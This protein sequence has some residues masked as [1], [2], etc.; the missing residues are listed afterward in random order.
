MRFYTRQ[1]SLGGAF[2]A[3]FLLIVTAVKG[4]DF[5]IQ[6]GDAV[7]ENVPG[8]G[9]GNLASNTETDIYTFSA[10]AGQSVFFERISAASAY[11][12]W[13][14]W[15]V[16]AP[17]GKTVL[18]SFFG[19]GQDGRI[20]LPE[21]GTYTIKLAA[22]AKD[23]TYFGAYSFRLRF[24]P[25]DPVFPIQVGQTVARDIPSEGAGD[26][27][28]AGARDL[29]SF[30]ASAGDQVSV[31]ELSV[32]SAFKGWLGWELRNPA[33]QRVADSWFDTRNEA[34]VT[35]PEAGVYQIQVF[36]KASDPSFLGDYSFTLRGVP[37]DQEFPIRLGDAVSDG[38]PGPGAGRIES[39]G[40]KDVYTFT[41]SADQRVIFEAISAAPAF[42][43]WLQWIVK[44][45]SGST[46]WSAY[47]GSAAD[48]RKTLPESGT[49]TVT[50]AAGATDPGYIGAYSF[51]IY[52]DVIAR[53]DTFTTAPAAA[54]LIPVEKFLCN[55]GAE[56]GDALSIE[57]PSAAS[58]Q[59]G[60]LVQADDLIVY[61]PKAGFTG[62]DSFSYVLRGRFGGSSSAT[63]TVHVIE[64]SA[65]NPT[66]V[67]VSPAGSAAHVCLLGAPK[68]T[69]TV[70][71]SGD[72]AI[73]TRAGAITTDD[74]G[75]CTYEY[76]PDAKSMQFYRFSAE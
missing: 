35:L 16:K 74:R 48:G 1:S 64:G 47:F 33:G 6:V 52:S 51:R 26:I 49:Y 15:T 5:T 71:L 31:D 54:L 62:I 2:C 60:T 55:D 34:R 59:G 18:S 39:P 46:V 27:E 58:A 66:V 68:A 73:W 8:P 45:P 38:M 21:S 17:S 20:T 76:T 36:A 12:G 44:A 69:Y 9:A 53:P 65:G 10:D 13:L 14:M 42:A 28:V 67:S 19:S 41:A 32:A 75:G 72:L 11:K 61:T 57:L 3:A 24:I 29:Y 37:R 4:E 22:G 23:P 63:E 70:Y 50:V 7:S 25:P 43:G 30:S 40:V 56:E